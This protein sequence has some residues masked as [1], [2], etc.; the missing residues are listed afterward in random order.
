VLSPEF[1]K[2]ACNL[3]CHQF[4]VTLDPARRTCWLRST[5][6]VFQPVGIFS[7]DDVGYVKDA[8][9]AATFWPLS[10]RE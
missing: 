10:V 9:A 1:D 5:R 8:I 3:P 6:N 2:L 7:S 4:A